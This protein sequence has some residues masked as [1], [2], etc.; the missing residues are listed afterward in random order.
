MKFFFGRQEQIGDVKQGYKVYRCL[1]SFSLREIPFE[2][3]LL[4]SLLSFLFL[5]E[6]FVVCQREKKMIALRQ[7]FL[8][9]LSTSASMVAKKFLFSR[10]KK[11]KSATA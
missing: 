2:S 1:N 3:M 4:I 9:L 10:V 6:K 7:Y 8:S 5:Q 11:A